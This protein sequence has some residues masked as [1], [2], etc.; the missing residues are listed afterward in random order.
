[1]DSHNTPEVSNE[2]AQFLNFSKTELRAI[3]NQ[4]GSQEE[5]EIMRTQEKYF[6]NKND[7]RNSYI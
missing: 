4:Y 2:V 1:M 3:I 7:S 6:I 5:R